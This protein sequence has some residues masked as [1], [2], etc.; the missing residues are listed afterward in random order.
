MAAATGRQLATG[1]LA[2][3]QRRGDLGE[4]DL[5]HVVQQE[6]RALQRRQPLQRQHQRHREIMRVVA[7]RLGFESWVVEHRLGQPGPDIGFAPA[8][9]RFQLIETEAGDD[10][11]QE[12]A[13]VLPPS[14]DRLRANADRLPAPNLPRR[15]SNRAS[16]RRAP[17]DDCDAARSS[18]PIRLVGR[19]HAACR[20]TGRRGAAHRD[21]LASLPMTR[22]R[23]SPSGTR[24]P[25]RSRTPATPRL[26]CP[27]GVRF[28][29]DAGR[30]LDRAPASPSR[31]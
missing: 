10:A 22:A 12:G 5:E 15:P 24:G 28:P 19:D 9:R 11:R 7:R 25:R 23:I 3:A 2:A 31:S 13:R 17:S 30:R 4:A 21:A 20:N 18:P 6:G 8:A 1:R 16:D 29:R 14:R 26:A 27:S